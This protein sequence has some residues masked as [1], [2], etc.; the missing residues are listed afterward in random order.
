[1]G[2]EEQLLTSSI[3]DTIGNARIAVIQLEDIIRGNRLDNTDKGYH[4]NALQEAESTLYFCVEKAFR[5]IAILAERL[6][7]PSLCKDIK[8]TKVSFSSLHDIQPEPNEDLFYC[9]PLAAAWAYF[10]SLESMTRGRAITGLGVFESILRKTPVI[11]K[12]KGIVPENETDVKNAVREVL[13]FCFNDVVKEMSIAKTLK[14]YKPD[15]GVT[16]LMAAAEYKYANTKEK[17]KS[18]LD[19]IYTDMKG[20]SGSH[21]WRSFYAVIYL[22][23]PFYS[24]EDVEHE[25]RLVKAELSWTPII[26]L[27]IGK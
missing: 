25:F 2:L 16:S 23:E 13:S 20:Y 14:V 1:M 6:H 10:V 4:A 7:L 17:A 27:G 21:E 19:G 26:V 5:D 8:D 9:P 22:T 11:I 12:S 24:Q 3:S 15:L 18:A